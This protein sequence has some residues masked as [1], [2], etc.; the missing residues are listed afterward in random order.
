MSYY[1]CAVPDN[2]VEYVGVRVDTRFTV[3]HFGYDSS[4]TANSCSAN[5]GTGGVESYH[6]DYFYEAA[7]YLEGDIPEKVGDHNNWRNAGYLSASNGASHP[8]PCGMVGYND[9]SA[10]WSRAAIS[11]TGWDMWT[12]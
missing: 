5:V 3:P 9:N 12:R 1:G 8:Y 10:R 2:S 11:C 4:N 6:T 7:D